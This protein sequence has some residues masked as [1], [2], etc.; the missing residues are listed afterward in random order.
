M[1]ANFFSK[2]P[3]LLKILPYLFFFIGAL[4]VYT[5]FVAN[6]QQTERNRQ[7]GLVG[8]TY[9]RATNCFLA[10]PADQRTDEYIDECYN[11]AEQATGTKVQ[12]F[13][14]GN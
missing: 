6:T 10:V 7:Q 1:V 2:N 8:Q 4:M 14:V 5:G 11:L 3:A 12:H 9:N 13:G